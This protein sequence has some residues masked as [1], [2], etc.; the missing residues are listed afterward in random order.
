MRL[1]TLR[2]TV[3][4]LGL[5]GLLEVSGL[6]GGLIVADDGDL[7]R[8]LGDG[9]GV[10]TAAVA[11]TATT[12]RRRGAAFP[13][14]QLRQRNPSLLAHHVTVLWF[15]GPMGRAYAGAVTTATHANLVCR[16]SYFFTA[17]RP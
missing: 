2:H 10:L 1:G 8:Q 16:R 4:L 5:R 3:G 7:P 9:H 6:R 15:V 12:R 14:E 13:G 17:P 11:P